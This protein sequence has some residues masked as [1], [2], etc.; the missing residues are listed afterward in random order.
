MHV[1]VRI[2]KMKLVAKTKMDRRGYLK[3]CGSE[4]SERKLDGSVSN[5]NNA[6]SDNSDNNANS[7]SIASNARSGSRTYQLLTNIHGMIIMSIPP[8]NS[9][10]IP[11]IKRIFFT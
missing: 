11:T 10:D 7:V 4:R 1:L 5:A 6:N 2:G 9:T 3:N 8:A